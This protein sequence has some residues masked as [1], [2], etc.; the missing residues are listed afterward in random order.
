[1]RRHPF[2]I[3]SK[4]IVVYPDKTVKVTPKGFVEGEGV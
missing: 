3:T 4:G 1:M 2:E